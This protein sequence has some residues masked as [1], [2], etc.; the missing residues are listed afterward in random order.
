MCLRASSCLNFWSTS[1]GDGDLS[2]GVE[3]GEPPSSAQRTAV[4]HFLG[5]GPRA[6]AFSLPARGYGTGWGSGYETVHGTSMA[7]GAWHESVDVIRVAR[8]KFS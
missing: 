5:G 7:C 6:A 2:L 4:C 1:L 3:E 8:D